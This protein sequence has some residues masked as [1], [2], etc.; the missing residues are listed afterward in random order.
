[1]LLL[2]AC[3]AG[4]ILSLQ[5]NIILGHEGTVWRAVFLQSGKFGVVRNRNAIDSPRW[6]YKN[7]AAVPTFWA[8]HRTT[9]THQGLG[10]F[11]DN[12]RGLWLCGIPFWFPTS[13]SALLLIFAWRR[14]RKRA[15]G[16]F[17]VTAAPSGKGRSAAP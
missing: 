14:S 5:R 4:W 3:V 6:S 7:Y 12:V 2:L 17:P 15:P 16:A 10:F 13:L 8:D 11:W 9:T 1:M